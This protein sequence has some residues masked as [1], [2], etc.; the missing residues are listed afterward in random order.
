MKLVPL[1]QKIIEGKEKRPLKKKIGVTLDER[2]SAIKER[3][4]DGLKGRTVTFDGADIVFTF[5]EG[6]P[7]EGYKLSVK[8]KVEIVAS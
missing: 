3:I 8:E 6:L 2:F 5:K 7:A 1:A 4:T